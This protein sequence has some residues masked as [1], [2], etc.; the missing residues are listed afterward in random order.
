M[1]R[2][3]SF[4]EIHRRISLYRY[5]IST[6]SIYFISIRTFKASAIYWKNGDVRIYCHNDHILINMKH[7]HA[8]TDTATY[9]SQTEVDIGALVVQ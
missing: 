5:L 8:I 3:I 7:Q 1:F 4:I 2:E 9:G 6:L